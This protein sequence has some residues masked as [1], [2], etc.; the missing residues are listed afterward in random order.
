[1]RFIN[2]A[3]RTTITL[4]E[5]G[6]S[7]FDSVTVLANGYEVAR[8]PYHVISPDAVTVGSSEGS[9]GLSD[10]SK[11]SEFWSTTGSPR[12]YSWI[13]DFY[14]EDYSTT[15]PDSAITLGDYSF[16]SSH[17]NH[18]RPT[19][20]I[21]A[22]SVATKSAGQVVLGFSE[23]QESDQR[24]L[25]VKVS[26]VGI[27][28][29]TVAYF[30]LR[31]QNPLFEFLEWKQNSGYPFTTISAPVERDGEKLISILAVSGKNAVAWN[32]ELGTIVMHVGSNAPIELTDDDFALI[33][34]DLLA[35]TGEVLGVSMRDP[36]RPQKLT[37][38][39]AQNYPN[40][41]NPT[42]TIRYSIASGGH[43]HLTIYDVRGAVVKRLV[44]GERK[45]NEYHVVWDGTDNKGTKV[46]SGVYFYRLRAPQ[47]TMSKKMLL[48]K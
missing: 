41:F 33:T 46:A 34:G 29:F 36:Q 3:Y 47:F 23:S 15:R 2:D 6:G 16:L 37:N 30:A 7:V 24:V 35:M 40:P 25:R 32:G 9:V 28:P 43:V 31:N 5:L 14:G 21:T 45:P 12:P 26:L 44:N 8:A 18:S 4:R 11:F 20:L 1:M 38:S 19:G 48:L 17:Y 10:W 22:G 39:L 27:E 13:V 42:T